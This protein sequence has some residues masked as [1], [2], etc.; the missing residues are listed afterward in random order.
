[1]PPGPAVV[2]EAEEPTQIA[3]GETE[4][5]MVLLIVTATV[6]DPVHPLLFVPFTV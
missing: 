5:E 1:V 4:T 3:A 2:R 6:E